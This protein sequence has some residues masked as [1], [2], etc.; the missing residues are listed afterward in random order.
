M[1]GNVHFLFFPITNNSCVDDV[2]S[3]MNCQYAMHLLVYV[4]LLL[5]CQSS[6]LIDDLG[7]DLLY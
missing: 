2:K 1:L 5:K 3:Q 4:S 7:S 6:V